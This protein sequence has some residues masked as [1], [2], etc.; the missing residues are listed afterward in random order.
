MARGSV[1]RLGVT[2][3]W[4]VAPAIAWGTQVRATL[5][6][7]AG[8]ADVR[9]ARI[10]ACLLCRAAGVL[11]GTARAR[12]GRLVPGRVP[13]RGPLPSVTDHVVETVAVGRKSRH[14]RGA[15]VAISTRVLVG[16]FALPG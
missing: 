5:E 2:R 14:R 7:L 4:S 9:L 1:D 11:R 3:G 6:H 13:V 10:V 8:Y 15:R 12:R 16:K